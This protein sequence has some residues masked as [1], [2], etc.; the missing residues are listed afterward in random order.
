MSDA[1]TI[2]VYD[3]RVMEYAELNAKDSTAATN[4]SAFIAA[5]P[6]KGRVLD[7]GCGPGS[8]AAAMAQAGLRVDATDASAEMVALAARH[9]GVT[10]TQA[11]FDDISGEDIYDAIWASFCLLH[12]PRAD[13]PDHLE[14]LHGAL[15]P[16]GIFYIGMKLGTG[17]ARDSIGRFYTYYTA[18]ALDTYLHK[19]GFTDLAHSF[20]SSRGMDGEMADYV[21]ITAHG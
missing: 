7:L 8:S 4:L 19:A 6:A 13:F 5:C 12:A 1:Q 9:S 10:A 15:K 20:G 17:E 2:K 18:D 14:A 16:G 21:T 3:A 11:M